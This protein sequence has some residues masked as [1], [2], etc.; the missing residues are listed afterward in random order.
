MKK[1]IVWLIS[2]VVVAILLIILY[3]RFFSWFP[4]NIRD[5]NVMLN[6]INSSISKELPQGTDATQ[7]KLFLDS[8][9]IE[10]SELLD[11]PEKDSNF[12]RSAK[13]DGKRNKIKS[14]I[15]AIKRDVGFS[16]LFVSWSIS[17]HFYFNEHNKLV[18]YTAAVIGTGP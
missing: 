1:V 7:V 16:G 9:K 12:L 2:I 11:E 10:H 6:K 3:L 8:R 14:Q 5:V 4:S 15:V 13:L 18:E 17:M